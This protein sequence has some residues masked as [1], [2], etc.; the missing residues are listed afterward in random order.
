MGS[1]VKLGPECPSVR[2]LDYMNEV[3]NEYAPAPENY[4][5]NQ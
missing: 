3:N 2:L 1:F 5:K 4:K